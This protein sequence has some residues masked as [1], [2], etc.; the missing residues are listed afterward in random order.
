[1]DILIIINIIYVKFSSNIHII[2]SKVAFS[3][4]RCARTAQVENARPELYARK[5]AVMRSAKAIS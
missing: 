3:R 2:K 4:A 5:A 1:M